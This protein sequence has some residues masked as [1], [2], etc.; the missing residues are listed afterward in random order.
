MEIACDAGNC[1]TAEIGSEEDR[2]IFKDRR[3]GFACSIIWQR[4][5]ASR[6]DPAKRRSV[7]KSNSVPL[8]PLTN[9]SLKRR[10]LLSCSF[11]PASTASAAPIV[12]IK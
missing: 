8:Q 3:Q 2:L 1:F 9:D 6:N 4:L 11:I 5:H 10:V 12:E 7:L